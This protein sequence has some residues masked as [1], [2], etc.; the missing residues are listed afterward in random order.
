MS[1]EV[2]VD[3]A[4]Q[5]MTLHAEQKVVLADDL[6]KIPAT[7][8]VSPERFIEEK[9]GIFRRMPLMLAP[10][11]E[12]PNPG[13]YKSMKP[14]GVPILL[15]RGDD[16]VVRAF[17]NACGHRGAQ[18]EEVGTGHASRFTCPYHGWTYNRNGELVGIASKE[19]FGEIDSDC[20]AL[21]ELPVMEKAGLIWGVLDPKSDIDIERFLSGYDDLLAHFGF[22]DWHLFETRTIEGPNWKVAYDGYLDYYHLPVLHK[23]TIGGAMTPHA[24]YYS[25]GPHQ[26]VTAPAR[27][28]GLR[29]KDEADWPMSELLVGVWTI[30]PHISI[31]SFQGGGRSVMISQLFPGAEVGTSYTTQFYLMETPPTPEQE[32]EAH[33]QFDLLE[34]VVQDEDYKTGKQVQESLASGARD[35]VLFGRNEGGGQQFHGW[36]QRILDTEDDG[37]NNLF[38]ANN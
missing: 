22:S 4:R 31:A 21:A 32:V 37:L 13:D 26:H 29:G 24:T 6:L 7:N 25:W 18:F 14:A 9:Q 36:V 35:H 20:Y 11:A 1:R 2:L 28:E 19:D 17:M 3:I 33:A 5:N 38:A 30:F 27:F 15:T 8:Y 16:G 23:D 10:T 34:F 12:I